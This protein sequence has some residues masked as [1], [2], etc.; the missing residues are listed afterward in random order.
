M[1]IRFTTTSK[2]AE[3]ILEKVSR[4]QRK[5]FIQEAIIYYEKA[6]RKEKDLHSVFL[7][8]EKEK[9]NSIFD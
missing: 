9:K 8:V 2:K 1:D 6:L 7:E 5:L 3:E 4:K